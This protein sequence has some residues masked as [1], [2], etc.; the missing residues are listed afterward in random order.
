MTTTWRRLTPVLLWAAMV[1]P[2]HVAAQALPQ[3]VDQA[4]HTNPDVL[5]AGSRRLAADEGLKQARA[6]YLPRI[7][8]NAATGRV[9]LDSHSTRVTGLSDTSYARHAADITI[10]QMLFDGFG[11]SSDVERQGA[12]ID[13]AA[14]RVGATAEDIA[15][16]TVGVYVEVLRRQE[17][18]AIGVANLEAHQHIYDQIRLGADNGVLRRADLYQAESR[19]ALAQANLRAEEGALQ[20]AMTAFLRVVGTPPQRL[21]R[22][23]SLAAVLPATEPEAQRVANA[24]HPA[25]GAGQADIAEA[26]AMRSQARSALWP[27]LD[28]EVG[29]ARDRDRVLGTTDERSVMLRVRYNLFRG[30]ADK[31]RINEASYQ[32]EEAEQN[33]ERLRRQVQESMSLAYNAYRTA[34]DRLVS[35]RQYVQASDATRVS[36]GRQFRIGQRSLLDL[37]NAENEYFSARTAYVAGQ[38]TELASQYRILAGM[39]LLLATLQVAP[40]SEA[41]MQVGMRAGMR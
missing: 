18:V 33:L 21:S 24:S 35:L 23:E 6:G 37:L 2:L 9:R 32:I 25:L 30:N 27:R 14:Y 36:Y 8:L 19:L 39:G 13:G 38:Y 11:V 4:V 10:T 34:Q 16:R 1:V 31:A 28:L 40:P 41:L 5:A 15:L 26:Q 20:D 12:R 7:D 17:T 22:P 29:A 3:A